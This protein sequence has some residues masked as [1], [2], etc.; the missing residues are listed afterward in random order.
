M[1]SQ[2]SSNVPILRKWTTDIDQCGEEQ[3]VPKSYGTSAHAAIEC[4]HDPY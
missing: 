2:P 1:I 4:L 3:Q